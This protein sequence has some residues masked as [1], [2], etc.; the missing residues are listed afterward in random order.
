MKILIAD[1][2]LKGQSNE[3]WKEG[4]ELSYA[5]KSLG[6]ECDVMGKNG[7]ISEF[8]IPKIANKYDLIIITE[9]YPANSGWGWWDWA[10]IKVPKVFWAIDTHLVNFLPWI[11]SCGIE[12]VAFNNPDDMIRY[13]LETSFWMPYAVSKKHHMIQY[14]GEKTRDTVFIGGLLPERKRICDK[15][16]IECLNVYGPDYIREMQASKICFNLSMSYDINAKYFEILSSGSFMLTN[17]NANFHE[18]MDYNEDIEKMFYKTEDELGDK[19]KYYLS[20]EE[21][22]EEIAKRVKDYIYENHSWENRAK[23]ILEYVS[24]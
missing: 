1:I 20:H 10:S 16:G 24:L 9:N 8:E 13:G 14:T 15:F 11:Q 3:D 7:I 18:Y 17:Y 2:L 12:H 21:E 23:L 5:F 4:Y 19:I 6:H 22:R